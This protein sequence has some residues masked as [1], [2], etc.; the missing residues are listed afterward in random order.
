MMP[1]KRRGDV[2]YRRLNGFAAMKPV[3]HWCSRRGANRMLLAARFDDEVGRSRTDRRLRSSISRIFGE[4]ILE[5]WQTSAWPG[6]RLM[7][8]T[9]IV[10]IVAFDSTLVEPMCRLEPC[11]SEWNH[12]HPLRLPEDPCVFR[13][14]D[15]W[16]LLVSVTHEMDAWVLSD[17]KVRGVRDE[18][19]PWPPNEIGIPRGRRN[20]LARSAVRLSEYVWNPHQ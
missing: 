16:P 14:G 20:F 5:T 4:R 12:S 2:Q 18:P 10:I 15:R 19:C 17:E 7:D 6:T 11:L 13:K 8:S 1:D 9:A 3:L